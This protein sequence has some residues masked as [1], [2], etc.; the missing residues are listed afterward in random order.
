MQRRHDWQQKLVV[1]FIRYISS[2]VILPLLVLCLN[3]SALA[4]NDGMPT[5]VLDPGHTPTQ[6]GALGVLGKYEVDYND[7]LVSKLIKVLRSAK[8]NVT[9]TR[10]SSE[11]ISL[12]DRVNIANSIQPGLFL[13]I[14]HD[15]AQQ[16]YLKNINLAQG[17][18][19][20]TIK[21]FSGYSIFTSKKNPQFDNSYRFAEIL[22]QSLLNLKR[23]P[24]LHHAENIA[25]ENRELL[26]ES[27]GIYRF[28]DLIVLAKT[29][30]P[31]VLLEIGVIVDPDD[32]HYVSDASNQD[33]MCQMILEA[34]QAY[35]AQLP[36]VHDAAWVP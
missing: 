31:A 16:I 21:T 29:K 4:K 2:L 5:I 24:T 9:V 1:I 20:Q 25:G 8:F 35:F 11:S 23:P 27:L 34:L 15:S 26:N 17:V 14:H 12:M 32:E 3:N 30:V 33:A 28:D 6:K 7:R 19:Y 22:G 13:S 10:S 18:G 36:S